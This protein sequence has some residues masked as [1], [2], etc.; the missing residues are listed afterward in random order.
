MKLKQYRNRKKNKIT[1]LVSVFIITFLI[2]G[3]TLA[4]LNAKTNIVNN[5][6][7]PGKVSTSIN[8]VFENNEKSNVSIK[9]TGNVTAYIRAAVVVTWQNKNGNVAP[10]T[11]EAGKD[12]TITYNFTNGWVE[13]SDGFYYWTKPVASETEVNEGKAESSNTGILITTCSPVEGKA[14]E[15]Y[16]LCVEIL[17]SGIQSLPTS[18]VVEN[19]S[20]GVESVNAD[21]SLKIKVNETTQ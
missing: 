2:T 20:S 13:S 11:P 3:G 7:T 18:I 21:G 19:W 12:Y 5:I 14:P 9:N 8:E 17:G 10:V 15:G 6:F 4:F 16:S 1:L